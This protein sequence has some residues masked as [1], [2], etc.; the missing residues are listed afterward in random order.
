MQ[1]HLLADEIIICDALVTRSSILL[2]SNCPYLI[3]QVKEL[4]HGRL[5]M[6]GWAAFFVQGAVTKAGPLQ[7]AIDFWRDPAA[8]NI[9]TELQ[10]FQGRQLLDLG[11]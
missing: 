5:A 3:M 4:K 9:F 7:N 1:P 10:H 6:L 2:T 8:N 11:V